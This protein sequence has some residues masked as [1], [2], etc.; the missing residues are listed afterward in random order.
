MILIKCLNVNDNEIWNV[1][2]DIIDNNLVL[3]SMV[4][5]IVNNYK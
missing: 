2:K 5:V 4:I 3:V 1:V